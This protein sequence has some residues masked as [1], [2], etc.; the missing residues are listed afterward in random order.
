MLDEAGM[1]KKHTRS[2]ARAVRIIEEE[3][4]WENN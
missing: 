1:N 3:L 4:C 2:V